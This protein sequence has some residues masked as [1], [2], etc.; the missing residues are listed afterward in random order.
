MLSDHER[1]VLRDLE[2]RFAAEDP[3]LIR[4]FTAPSTP[5][6]G[7]P[8]AAATVA[9]VVALLLGAPLLLAGSVVG[10][11]AVTA[12]TALIWAAWRGSTASAE[13]PG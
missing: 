7:S 6:A 3:D 5:R 13:P 10:A 12:T 11:L 9:G 8:E 2:R 4:S 1:R